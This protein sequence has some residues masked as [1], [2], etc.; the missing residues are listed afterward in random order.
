MSLAQTQLATGCYTLFVSLYQGGSKC[1]SETGCHEENVTAQDGRRG[2]R[3]REG[4]GRVDTEHPR[5]KRFGEAR[6]PPD[7][8]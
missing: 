5:A 7:P 3:G 4:K 8:L 1:S 6:P 2:A